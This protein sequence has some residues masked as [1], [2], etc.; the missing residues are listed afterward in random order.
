[1]ILQ[2]PLRSSR[3]HQRLEEPWIKPSTNRTLPTQ[4]NSEPAPVFTDTKIQV[5]HKRKKE[6]NKATNQTNKQKTYA[7]TI[8]N[9]KCKRLYPRAALLKDRWL[10][11]WYLSTD[12]NGQLTLLPPTTE[13][14]AG[15]EGPWVRRRRRIKQG[16]TLYSLYTLSPSLLPLSL[17]LSLSPSLTLSQLSSSGKPRHCASQKST[18]PGPPQRK[19]ELR[20]K[21]SCCRLRPCTRPSRGVGLDVHRQ[22]GQ[23]EQ[24]WWWWWY[25]RSGC[26]NYWGNVKW[27]A[28]MC[29]S[30]LALSP[31]QVFGVRPSLH[32]GSLP[33]NGHAIQPGYRWPR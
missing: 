7:F 20:L 8:F 6:K 5:F 25:G 15:A 12:Q 2:W 22:E 30:S 16:F 11:R 23:R 10:P 9:R 17:S 4:S 13:R 27:C 32:R 26:V 29:Y 24:R 21:R 33:F 19:K 14:N 28:P 3:R 1:M 31:T 18:P